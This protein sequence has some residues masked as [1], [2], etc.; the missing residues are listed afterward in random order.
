MGADRENETTAGS[1]A[2]THGPEYRGHFSAAEIANH[3]HGDHA[4]ELLPGKILKIR[5]IGAWK[6]IG[7][8]AP[9]PAACARPTISLEISMPKTD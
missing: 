2:R 6:V 7:H 3:K 1:E 4:V 5:G 9:I 8:G